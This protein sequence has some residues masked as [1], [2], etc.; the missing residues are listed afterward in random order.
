M[1][2]LAPEHDH[3]AD[4]RARVSQPHEPPRN[5]FSLHAKSLVHVMKAPQDPLSTRG[6]HSARGV[7]GAR[8]HRIAWPLVAHRAA[9]AYLAIRGRSRG[10]G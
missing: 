8:A 6:R 7:H 5:P 2:F 10:A 9:S 3:R 4:E 1:L